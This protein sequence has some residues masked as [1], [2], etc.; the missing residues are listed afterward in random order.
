M[1]LVAYFENKR[2]YKWIIHAIIYL[3]IISSFLRDAS[4]TSLLHRSKDSELIN[5]SGNTMEEWESPLDSSLYYLN[6]NLHASLNFASEAEF[7]AK[8]KSKDELDLKIFALLGKIYLEKGLLSQAVDFYTAYL[9]A[10]QEGSYL[11][12]PMTYP[13]VLMGIAEILIYSNEPDKAFPYLLEAGQVLN[14]PA[15]KGSPLIAELHRTYAKLYLEKEAYVKA[16][17]QLKKGLELVTNAAEFSELKIS[18]LNLMGEVYAL[19]DNHPLSIDYFN[20]AYLLAQESADYNGISQALMGLAINAYRLGNRDQ[21]ITESLKALDYTQALG[22]ELRKKDLAA[23]LAKWY[24]EKEMNDSSAHFSFIRKNLVILTNKVDAV[25]KIDKMELMNHMQTQLSDAERDIAL[26]LTLKIML[27]IFFMVMIGEFFFLLFRQKLK[28]KNMLKTIKETKVRLDMLEDEKNNL[29]QQL[30]RNEKKVISNIINFLKKDK[31]M[32]DIH[33]QMLEM[34]KNTKDQQVLTEIFED[35]YQ[36]RVTATD[37]KVMDMFFDLYK[38][39]LNNLLENYPSLTK[40]E[41]FLCILFLLNLNTNEI[42]E[43]QGITIESLRVAKSRL[44]K[45]FNFSSDEINLYDYLRKYSV[46]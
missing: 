15:Y 23:Y 9:Q 24:L 46:G 14:A 30:I 32:D 26:S 42:A 8:E 10:I 38:G 44:R 37:E 18:F 7:L 6:R 27:L 16:H 35:F 41:Q 29:K 33:G 36:L 5:F 28:Q 11:Q 3:G 25:A 13:M 4:S 39:Y 45:K 22:N 1:V 34:K 19:M 17:A 21:A 40:N 2:N 20:S 31:K 43:I 12:K